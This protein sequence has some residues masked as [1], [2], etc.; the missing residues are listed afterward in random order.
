MSNADHLIDAG[1]TNV[2]QILLEL[3]VAKNARQLQY[4]K[5]KTISKNSMIKNRI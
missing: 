1:K 5:R 4:K 3:F 2:A